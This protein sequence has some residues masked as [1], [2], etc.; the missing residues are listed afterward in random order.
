MYGLLIILWKIDKKPAKNCKLSSRQETSFEKPYDTNKN[1]IYYTQLNALGR[2]DED[3]DVR[4]AAINA[5]YSTEYRA[6][7][8]FQYRLQN[9]AGDLSE[10]SKVKAVALAT[11]SKI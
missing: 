5:I 9:I 2:R 11:L 8:D 3:P 4:I 7:R 6:E 10:N 1:N